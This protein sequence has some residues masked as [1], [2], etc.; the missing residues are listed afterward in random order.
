MLEIN[1][2]FQTKEELINAITNFVNQQSFNG[3]I[4]ETDKQYTIACKGRSEFKCDA[5]IHALYRKKDNMFVIKRIR[6][7]H[8][9]PSEIQQNIPTNEFIKREIE[10]FGNLK[11]SELVTLFSKKGLKMS[12]LTIYKAVYE[13]NEEGYKKGMYADGKYY[14][15]IKKY[16]FKKENK[17]ISENE[18][19]ENENNNKEFN[20]QNENNDLSFADDEF[21]IKKQNVNKF[22]DVLNYWGK[23]FKSFNPQAHY[24]NG[25]D[26]IVVEFPWYNKIREV[27]DLKIC[28]RS[29]GGFIGYGV[30]YDPTDKPLIK[31]LCITDQLANLPHFINQISE[32]LV[33]EN[34][35]KVLKI[36]TKMNRP[37]TVKTRILCK[38]VYFKTTDSQEVA[39][40]HKVCNSFDN[41]EYNFNLPPKNYKISFSNAEL[42]SINNFSDIDL[43]FIYSNIYNLN[44]LDALNAI[45]KFIADDIKQRICNLENEINEGIFDRN[46]LLRISRKIECEVKDNKVIYNNNIFEVELEKGCCSCG[47]FQ[48]LLIPCIHALAVINEKKEDAFNYVSIL[49]SKELLREMLQQILPVVNENIKAACEKSLLRNGPGRPKKGKKINNEIELR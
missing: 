32:Y 9:C 24:I 23:E 35:K 2:T 19:K 30:V 29:T 43:D 31:Y 1:S 16:I 17:S 46:V 11:I 26:W 36:L 45:I 27:V 38:E 49:Y 6:M 47:M 3:D 42:F 10:N 40:A 13:N 28:A 39:L 34:E 8:K 14:E 33:V 4:V 25:N 18:N 15:E 22:I 44:L 21:A 12:Y 20:K 7:N 41:S 48:R 37:F 5:H